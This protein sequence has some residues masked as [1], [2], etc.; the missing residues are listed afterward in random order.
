MNGALA[1]L[2]SSIFI[3][4]AT[5]GLPFTNDKQALSSDS[6]RFLVLADWGGSPYPPFTTGV[7]VRVAHQMAL[8]AEKEKVSFVLALGDNFYMNGVVGFYDER[9]KTTFEE[10]YHQESLNIPWYIIAGN[11]DHYGTVESQI[12]YSTISNRWNFPDF[13]YKESKTLP[14]GKVLDILFLDTYILCGPT[15]NTPFGHRIRAPLYYSWAESQWEWIQSNLK[16]S[17]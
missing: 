10:V 5:K 17:K 14:G 11:H 1:I 4:K 9:F 6:V 2:F 13:Y 12:L 16:E 3:W 7:Q 15:Y 8:K